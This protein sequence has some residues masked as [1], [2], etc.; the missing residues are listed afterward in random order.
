MLEWKGLII[1]HPSTHT[2]PFI[3]AN[4]KGEREREREREKTL[5]GHAQPGCVVGVVDILKI[6]CIT[7]NQSLYCVQYY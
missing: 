7:K 3:Q 4:R 1:W 6:F 5:K 2:K